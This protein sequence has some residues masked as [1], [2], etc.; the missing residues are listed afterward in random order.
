MPSDAQLSN[1]SRWKQRTVTEQAGRGAQS[2]G[3]AT[4][5]RAMQMLWRKT[6]CLRTSLCGAGISQT[7]DAT[8]S[9]PW[10]C[11]NSCWPQ[12]TQG[13]IQFNCR[14]FY[15]GNPS[16]LRALPAVDANLPKAKQKT[17]TK[18][19]TRLGRVQLAMPHV[20]VLASCRCSTSLEKL[21]QHRV[22]RGSR[23]CRRL[24]KYTRR[25]RG[26][27]KP[28]CLIVGTQ[29][30]TVTHIITLLLR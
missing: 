7:K 9:K 17:L 16:T 18:L 19:P 22:S 14:L 13:T 1:K 20:V 23:C 25:R 30:Q 11:D 3:A 4:S 21:F 27:L 29:A 8:T 10:S 15:V 6:V 26:R 24:S 28:E 2:A 12:K 5:R